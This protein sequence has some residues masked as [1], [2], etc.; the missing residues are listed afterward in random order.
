MVIS[1]TLQDPY[2]NKSI[3]FVRGASTSAAVQIDHVV[4]LENAWKSGAH[5]WTTA[6]KYRFSNDPYNLLAVDGDANQEKGSASADLWLP[7]NSSYRCDY[8]SR[9]IAVKAKYHLSV[10]SSERQAMLTVLHACPNQ[11]L[12]DE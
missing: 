6:D 3:A 10:T 4:A 5:A 1:G 7:S 11:A 12:P 9:Q 2:T 8:V